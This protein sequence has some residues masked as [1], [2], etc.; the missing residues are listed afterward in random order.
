MQFP[1]IV[2]SMGVKFY[3]SWDISQMSH[4]SR[5][6][7]LGFAFM[8]GLPFATHNMIRCGVTWQRILSRSHM[9]RVHTGLTS[10]VSHGFT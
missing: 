4:G 8:L 3:V 9:I 10:A 1:L 6:G 2:W 5:V 7:F